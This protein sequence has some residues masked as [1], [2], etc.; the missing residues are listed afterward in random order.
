MYEPLGHIPLLDRVAGHRRRHDVRR[1]R[2]RT[3]TSTRHSATL[4][5]VAAEHRTHGRSLVPLLDGRRELGARVG[6]RRRVGPRSARDR[7]R[8]E[9]HREVRAR[10]GRCERTAVDVVEPLVDDAGARAPRPAAPA[11][12]RARRPRSHAGL[13]SSGRSASR[14]RLPDPL[15]FWAYAEFRG[16][17]RSTSPKIRTRSAIAR[18]RATARRWPSCSHAALRERRGPARAARPPRLSRSQR[19]GSMRYVQRRSPS[20]MCWVRS[21]APS[22]P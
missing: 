19:R 6:A 15:P 20:R 9:R 2:R 22:G 16:T 17:W 4:F 5:G 8:R 21:I 3:S 13:E 11:A 14:S 10:A 12:R 7:R 18:T 1:A